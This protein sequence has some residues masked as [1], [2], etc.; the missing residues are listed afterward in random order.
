LDSEQNGKPYYPSSD[1]LYAP[2]PAHAV[3]VFGID[4][5]EGVVYISDSDSAYSATS[6]SHHDKTVASIE[7]PID[8]LQQAR[9]FKGRYPLEN[10]WLTFD[11]EGMWA[12]DWPIVFDAIRET[13]T[14]MHCSSSKNLGL[15]GIL[16]FSRRVKNWNGYGDEKLCMACRTA[17]SMISATGGTGGGAFRRMYGEFLKQC[18]ES[19]N[20]NE[21][22]R[23][24]REYTMLSELWEDVADSFLHLSESGQRGILDEI[25]DSLAYIHRKEKKLVGNLCMFVYE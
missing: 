16:L 6:P 14:I 12:V 4:E 10:R 21:L 17:Y 13:C 1:P 8:M 20:Q 25:S 3:V 18:A 22:A 24:G 19:F 2:L 23:L 5:E 9:R 15:K 7:I 11:L